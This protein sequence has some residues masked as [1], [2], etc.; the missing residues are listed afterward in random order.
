M[1]AE[2]ELQLGK[3]VA[4]IS[5]VWVGLLGDFLLGSREV[6][7][8]VIGEMV[9]LLLHSKVEEA[10]ETM[11]WSEK[12]W[13]WVLIVKFWVAEVMML[14]SVVRPVVGDDNRMLEELSE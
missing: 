2:I 4:K 5:A 12:T 6:E 9:A 14:E 7:V 13:D 8:I 10:M 3:N 11:G 1:L